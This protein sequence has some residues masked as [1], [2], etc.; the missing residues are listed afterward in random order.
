MG[1]PLAEFEYRV[2]QANQAFGGN[3][4]GLFTDRGG[5]YQVTPGDNPLLRRATNSRPWLPL[6][7]GETPRGQVLDDGAAPPS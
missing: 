2:R 4:K 7:P 1:D 5:V 3:E 6:G